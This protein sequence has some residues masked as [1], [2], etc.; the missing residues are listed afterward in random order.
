MKGNESLSTLPISNRSDEDLSQ[1]SESSNSQKI[2]QESTIIPSTSFSLKAQ[3]PLM[4]SNNR[5][6]VRN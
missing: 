5:K 1:Q 3:S 6:I 2:A 4:L